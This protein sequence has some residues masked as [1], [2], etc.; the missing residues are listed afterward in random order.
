MKLY[1][2]TLG[3]CNR[4]IAEAKSAGSAV[5]DYT[6]TVLPERKTKESYIRSLDDAIRKFIACGKMDD[7]RIILADAKEN[8][9]RILPYR[10][11]GN[12]IE[13]INGRYKVK[14]YEISFKEGKVK[15]IIH[16][17]YYGT[18]TITSDGENSLEKMVE[19]DAL[20]EILK[21]YLDAVMQIK[22]I[23]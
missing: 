5:Y 16:F 12:E 23:L 22:Q 21:N 1:G 7:I 10:V 17:C 20:Q 9:K 4:Y 14:K 19:D 13:K 11:C 6:P 8:N 2:G 18:V 15:L 3:I